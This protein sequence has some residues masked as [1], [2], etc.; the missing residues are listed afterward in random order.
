[1][2]IKGEYVLRE[3]GGDFILVPIGSTAM[4]MNG[5]ITLDEVAVDIWKGMESGKTNEEILAMILNKY[6]VE[7]NVAKADMEEFMDKL[8]EAGLAIR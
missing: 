7:E 3:I 2:K 1:M 6:E 8:V 5:L 4:T